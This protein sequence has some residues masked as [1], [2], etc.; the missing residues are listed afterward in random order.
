MLEVEV[1]T[2][3]PPPLFATDD[4]VDARS[5]K[6]FAADSII[7]TEYLLNSFSISDETRL[8][9]PGNAINRIIDRPIM[10]IDPMAST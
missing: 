7:L 4:I 6:L 10:N 9:D 5:I 8:D 3:V 2:P 1:S